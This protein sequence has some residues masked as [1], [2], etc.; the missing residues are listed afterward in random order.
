MRC[1]ISAGEASEEGEEEECGEAGGSSIGVVGRAELH[2]VKVL[3]AG[4][5][6][7]GFAE[8]GGDEGGKARGV[9]GADARCEGGVECIEVERDEGA[10]ARVV[11]GG[12]DGG[13]GIAEECGD[14]GDGS[15]A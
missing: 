10:V 8:S 6:A 7:G 14:G 11:E 9:D 13:G 5:S 4:V 1:L 12:L 2:E 3:D 15:A